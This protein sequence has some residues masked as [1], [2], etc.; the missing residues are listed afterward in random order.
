VRPR[1]M[2]TV[3]VTFLWIFISFAEG[4]RPHVKKSHHANH[5]LAGEHHT[6][7][8]TNLSIGAP[9]PD[10]LAKSKEVF[11]LGAESRLSMPGDTMLFQYGDGEGPPGFL[12]NLSHLLS[13][14]YQDKVPIE[15]L[16]LTSGASAGVYLAMSVLADKNFIAFVESPTYFILLHMLNDLGVGPNRIIPIPLANDGLDVNYLEKQLKKKKKQSRKSK[17]DSGRYWAFVYSICTYHNPTGVSLSPAKSKKLVRLSRKFNFLIICDDVYNLLH[18]NDGPAPKRVLAFDKKIPGRRSVISNGSFS[19]IL[20]PGL[21]LGW[22][23]SSPEI[24]GRLAGSGVVDS[25]GA[26]NQVAAGIV[27]SAMGLGLVKKNIDNLKNTYKERMNEVVKV[28][29]GCLPKSFQV[30]DP[31][32]GYFIWVTG[33]DSFD[34]DTFKELCESKYEVS[35]IPG[36]SCRSLKPEEGIQA[37]D[38]SPKQLTAM[39]SRNSFRISIGFYHKHTLSKAARRICKAVPYILKN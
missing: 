33:P 4:L 25:G 9:G 30:T 2:H 26:L 29:R 7:H 16:M 17:L 38:A 12:S 19:K 34:A 37:P 27:G 21:R 22:Y 8:G 39:L 14:G 11:R 6:W 36:K 10:L 28:L 23:E 35:F 1:V 5:S 3:V 31:M 32:G 13:D 18:Y 20:A 15:E 24:I